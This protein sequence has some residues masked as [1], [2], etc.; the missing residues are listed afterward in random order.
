MIFF[1]ENVLSQWTVDHYSNNYFNYISVVDS[2]TVWVVGENQSN[3]NFILR[4][5]VNG[6]W[7]SIPTNGIFDSLW[8]NCITA[9]DQYNA[10]VT[11]YVGLG[12]NGNAHIY[13][14]T[15]GGLNWIVQVNT[16]AELEDLT[17]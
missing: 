1:S 5:N 13:R 12:Q 8:I 9:K 2:N 6:V 11:D 15:N 17:V 14:T 7:D 3:D 16:G 4:R 10:W